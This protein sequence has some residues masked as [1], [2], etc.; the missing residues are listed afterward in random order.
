VILRLAHSAPL[1]SRC[2]SGL[3]KWKEFLHCY[4]RTEYESNMELLWKNWSDEIFMREIFPLEGPFTGYKHQFIAV[5]CISSWLC[6]SDGS[7]G[8]GVTGLGEFRL[9]VCVS[10]RACRSSLLL[11]AV[12]FLS[13]IQY[14]QF[15]D[16]YCHWLPRVCP[17]RRYARWVVSGGMRSVS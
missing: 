11:M 2:L 14:L 4:H 8:R 7:V 9:C 17:K 15:V 6:W 10:V 13:E 3:H 12:L 16:M 5:S 1:K